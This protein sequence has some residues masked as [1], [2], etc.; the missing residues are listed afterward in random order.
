MS[1]KGQKTILTVD[2]EQKPEVT[3][4]EIKYILRKMTNKL[5]P[6]EDGIIEEMI[7]AR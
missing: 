1:D 2:S 4:K 5:T 3:P 6:E 7:V